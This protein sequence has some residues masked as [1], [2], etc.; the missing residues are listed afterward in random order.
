MVKLE[1][2]SY[3]HPFWTGKMREV[4]SDGKIDSFICDDG[5]KRALEVHGVE[6]GDVAALAEVLVPTTSGAQIPLN[7]LATIRMH[8]G[9]PAIKSENARPN[10]WVYVDLR[11][12]DVGSW[13]KRAK[14]VVEE[15]VELPPG[16]TI[17][18]SG[19]YEYMQRAKQRLLVIVPITL[20]LIFL[21][22]YLNTKS[23][24]K[25]AIVL[26]AIPF[27]VV[28]SVWLLYSL[29][30]NWSIAVWVGIIALAGLDAE[31]G[32][33]MLLYLDIAWE[34]W[35][36]KGRMATWADLAEAA[37]V[38]VLLERLLPIG[39]QGQ[40]GRGSQQQ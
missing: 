17:F 9:P 6:L 18:W 20:F 4:D 12:I 39:F 37:L 38:Q 14:Q 23:I 28:G 2:S 11:G 25:T 34:R 22:L 36:K 21:I 27:S 3:S 16:Y 35:K 33:V 40:Q 26:S 15:N 29:H 10:A 5:P 24:I 32:V 31:T 1:V 30:Y 7:Q 8:Q 13:V 19:Q